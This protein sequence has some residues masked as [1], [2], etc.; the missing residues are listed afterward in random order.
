MKKEKIKKERKINK[1]T[2]IKYIIFSII[3]ITITATAIYIRI[4]KINEEIKPSTIKLEETEEKQLSETEEKKYTIKSYNETYNK[5]AIQITDCYDIKG[6]IEKEEHNT[7][8]KISKDPY[9]NYIEIKGI[10][11]QNIQNSINEK[12]RQ[13]AYNLKNDKDQIHTIIMG[14]FSNILSVYI[15]NDRIIDD[16]IRCETLN[17]DLTTGKEIPLQDIFISSAPINAILTQGLYKALAWNEANKEG[18]EAIHD[19][20]NYDTSQYEDISIKFINKYNKNKN[21][22]KYTITPGMIE[23][24]GMI[25]EEILG[26]KPESGD[27]RIEINFLDHLEEI[28]IYKRYL[29]DEDIYQN[30]NI[31][32]KNIIVLTDGIEAQTYRKRISYGKIQDNIFIEEAAETYGDNNIDTAIQYIKTLSNKEQEKLKQETPKNQ[33][34]FFQRQFIIEEKE[35]YYKIRINTSKT[36][37]TKDYF[38]NLAFKDYIILKQQ[39]NVAGD[40]IRFTNYDKEQFPNLQISET[41]EEEMYID[42][43]GK[44]IGTTEEEAIRNTTQET[45]QVQEPQQEENTNTNETFS[46][47]EINPEEEPENNETNT[48]N[49]TNTTNNTTHTNESNNTTNTTNETTNTSH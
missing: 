28:A 22:I 3:L 23:I 6:K 32:E 34:L 38:N 15:Y 13:K 33:G 49:T 16:A 4:N 19:V 42:K 20:N 39:I 44:Y 8:T 12:L 5:N 27:N 11:N 37:C 7:N 10:K 40:M 41:T 47:T 24:Y 14:N 9:V 35:N 31:G 43:Q 26:E 25:D 36:E 46:I 48:S 30:T 2:I 17:I 21:N 1:K 29:T 45:N 18:F